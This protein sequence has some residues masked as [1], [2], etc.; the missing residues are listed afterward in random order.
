VVLHHPPAQVLRILQLTG[1]DTLPGLTIDTTVQPP[2]RP[3]TGRPSPALDVDYTARD[4]GG[5]PSGI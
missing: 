5:K 1:W 4:E 2:T 3:A